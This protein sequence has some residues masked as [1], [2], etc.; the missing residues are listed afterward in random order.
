MPYND[1]PTYCIPQSAPRLNYWIGYRGPESVL[2]SFLGFH[3]FGT[4]KKGRAIADPA[5]LPNYVSTIGDY[6]LRCQ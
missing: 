4:F 2:D 6:C 1:T 3:L 5:I